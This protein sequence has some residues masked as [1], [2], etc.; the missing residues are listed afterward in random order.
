MTTALQLK[1]VS[2]KRYSLITV[3][4]FFGTGKWEGDITF[5]TCSFAAFNGCPVVECCSPVSVCHLAHRP[6]PW[7]IWL[8]QV[9]GVKGC[10]VLIE[11]TVK[12]DYTTVCAQISRPGVNYKQVHAHGNSPQTSFHSADYEK[13]SLLGGCREVYSVYSH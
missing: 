11:S 5:S 7:R 12:G 9:F 13:I 8:L 3:S 10:F 4:W 1:A 2:H 6:V